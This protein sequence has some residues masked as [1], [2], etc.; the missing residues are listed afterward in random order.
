MNAHPWRIG[1]V[2]Y[3]NARPLLGR[4]PEGI[5]LDHPAVLA[6]KLARHELDVALVPVFEWFR[7]PEYLAVGGS[8]I[9]ARGEVF[10]VII[11]TECPIQEI[12]SVQLDA[13][14][15][16][17]NHL[18]QVLLPQHVAFT[19]AQE[20]SLPQ[21]DRAMVL[22]GDRAIEF[23]HTHGR[24]YLYHDLGAWWYR[25]TGLPFVFALWLMHPATAQADALSK[26]LRTKLEEGRRLIPLIISQQAD[27]A[28]AARYLTHHIS[29]DIDQHAQRGIE[30]FARRTKAKKLIRRKNFD[31]WKFATAEEHPARESFCG[32]AFPA[33]NE[34][35]ASRIAH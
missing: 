1:C 28:F 35:V 11:A 4:D 34:R 5:L 32:E 18:A 15:R 26:E 12:A 8:G 27:R 9:V 16:T 20:I 23:R 7:H 24:R 19:S 30:E 29:F 14:S 2:A 22:I 21:G 3:L 10:S 31:V 33:R 17:S 25:E 13:A 6:D